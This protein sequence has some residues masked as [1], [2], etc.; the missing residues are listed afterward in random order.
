MRRPSVDVTIVL[1]ADGPRSRGDE[2]ERW[3]LVLDRTDAG[4]Y[5]RLGALPGSLLTRWGLGNAHGEC[6]RCENAHGASLDD[7]RKHAVSA[8]VDSMTLPEKVGQMTQVEFASITSDEV[9][10]WSIGSVLSGGGGNPGDG[11]PR[12][13]RDSVDEFVAGSRRSRLGIPILYGTDAVHGHNNVIGATIF[14]HNIGLG[15]TG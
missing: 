2:H 7:D 6:T 3:G 5:L 13:W 15:A 11:S 10:A 8:L 12:A 14:P 1:T 4:P 9:A